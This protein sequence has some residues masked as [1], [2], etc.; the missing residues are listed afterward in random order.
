[1]KVKDKPEE[2]KKVNIIYEENKGLIKGPTIVLKEWRADCD[3]ATRTAYL[4]AWESGI[5]NIIMIEMKWTDPKTN[6]RTGH[7]FIVLMPKNKDEQ[8]RIYDFTYYK[9]GK[10]IVVENNDIEAAIR[11]EYAVDATSPDFRITTRNNLNEV[12]AAHYEFVGKYYAKP[13]IQNWKNSEEAYKR[14]A[15]LM[16]A[17]FEYIW[18]VAVSYE[19]QHRWKEALEFYKKCYEF[20][21]GKD[22]PRVLG[23]LGTAHAKLGMIKE[24]EE[25]LK[26]ALGCK[27]DK[28]LR[29][30]IEE[31]LE[32]I[33][34]R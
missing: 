16:P 12:E 30:R 13:S 9:K 14:A 21:E 1:M 34:Q 25:L 24:A 10:P 11:K 31:N 3:E 26:Q 33:E 29:D 20:E 28:K 2:G 15:S 19:N 6:E 17:E 27:P 18:G 5:T 7:S 8:P 23:A 4:I 22:N 32:A